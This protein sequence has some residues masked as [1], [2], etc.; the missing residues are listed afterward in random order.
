MSLVSMEA[1]T[2]KGKERASLKTNVASLRLSHPEACPPAGKSYFSTLNIIWCFLNNTVAGSLFSNLDQ[3]WI[4][5]RSA[6]E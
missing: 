2:D 4:N 3:S 6:K 1:S 5:Y